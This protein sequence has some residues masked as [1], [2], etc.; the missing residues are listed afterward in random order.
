[1]TDENIPS[2]EMLFE[3]EASV[4]AEINR[5]IENAGILDDRTLMEMSRDKI[6]TEQGEFIKFLLVTL[7]KIEKT[8]SPSEPT[9]AELE[10]A[11][12]LAEDIEYLIR[13]TQGQDLDEGATFE[14]L[15]PLEALLRLLG[16]LVGVDEPTILPLQRLQHESWRALLRIL[17]E[18]VIGDEPFSTWKQRHEEQ[19]VA[20]QNYQEVL[21]KS[22]GTLKGLMTSFDELISQMRNEPEGSE[23]DI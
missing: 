18:L 3:Y 23:D 14:N 21:K 1:M 9:E 5:I 4:R 6:R 16:S 19:R 2:E 13:C 22:Q 15:F 12:V 20:L 11:D 8:P 10:E 7:V 17:A